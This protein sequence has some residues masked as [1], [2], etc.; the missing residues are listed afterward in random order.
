MPVIHEAHSSRDLGGCG[1]QGGLPLGAS[2]VGCGGHPSNGGGSAKTDVGAGVGAGVGAA[3][4]GVASATWPAP[5]AAEG[6]R[7]AGRRRLLRLAPRN[8]QGGE[9]NPRLRYTPEN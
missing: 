3:R 4:T 8:A 1:G 9:R 5:K 2:S 6:A 7:G